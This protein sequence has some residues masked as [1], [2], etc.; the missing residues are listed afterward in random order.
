MSLSG[1]SAG[2][3]AGV[4]SLVAL[5]PSWCGLRPEGC[6]GLNSHVFVEVLLGI[7][8]VFVVF[9]DLAPIEFRAVGQ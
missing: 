9:A 8:A 5:G 4:G 3:L 7:I 1:S 6:M 2:V